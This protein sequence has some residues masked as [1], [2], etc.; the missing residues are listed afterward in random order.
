MESLRLFTL[1]KRTSRILKLSPFA[2]TVFDIIK[3]RVLTISMVLIFDCCSEIDYVAHAYNETEKIISLNDCSRCKDMPQR[4][5][6]T[7]LTL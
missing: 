7:H 4:D 6:T 2:E 5:Q 3:D 1:R